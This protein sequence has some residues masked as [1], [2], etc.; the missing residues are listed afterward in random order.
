VRV[1][2]A[3]GLHFLTSFF[4]VFRDRGREKKEIQDEFQWYK[5]YFGG[6][7]LGAAANVV[8]RLVDGL[9]SSLF[10]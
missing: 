6:N 10:L 3:L 9:E 5:R 4:V 8:V 2:T 7:K 1:N